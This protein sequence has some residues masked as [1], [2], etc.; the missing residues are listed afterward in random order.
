MEEALGENND[1]L[2]VLGL[3]K[4]EEPCVNLSGGKD[5]AKPERA[6]RTKVKTKKLS[7]SPSLSSS[8]ESMCSS[9]PEKEKKKKYPAK[10]YSR[11]TFLEGE[12]N[13]R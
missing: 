9:S 3:L 1:C 10:K 13:L 7:P 6:S 4:K 5:A 8:D 11:K 12:E 2:K